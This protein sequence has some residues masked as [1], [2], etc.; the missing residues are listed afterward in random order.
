MIITNS[1]YILSQT[2]CA[3]SRQKFRIKILRHLALLL[4]E[5]TIRVVSRL[6]GITF[7]SRVRVHADMIHSSH[8]V[9]KCVKENMNVTATMSFGFT[10]AQDQKP[11]LHAYGSDLLVKRISAKKRTDERSKNVLCCLQ[12]VLDLPAME[13]RY[14]E[15]YSIT[16]TT[17]FLQTTPT[18]CHPGK[19]P[20]LFLPIIDLNPSDLTCVYSTHDFVAT[21]AKIFLVSPIVIF[22]QQLYWKAVQ[23]VLNEAQLKATI[24]HVLCF[25]LQGPLATQSDVSSE[26]VAHSVSPEMTHELQVVKNLKTSIN[27]V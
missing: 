4:I 12:Y 27:K 16:F 14:L 10:K 15:K 26:S 9:V 3:N 19:S 18:G 1:S 23:M 24:A 13:A 2:E 25:L 22:D 20:V 11:R 17:G 8:I 7:H 21:Q 6:K 5:R